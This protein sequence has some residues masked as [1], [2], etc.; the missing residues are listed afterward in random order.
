MERGGL[1][2]STAYELSKLPDRDEQIELGARAEAEWLSRDEV[3]EEVRKRGAVYPSQNWEEEGLVET[4]E[5]AEGTLSARTEITL[6]IGD[7]CSIVVT[8]P[9]FVGRARFYELLDQA[10]S[11]EKEKIAAPQD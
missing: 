6:Q 7:G 8:A 11:K 2:W 9:G 4:S 3:I 10:I 1:C 5:L